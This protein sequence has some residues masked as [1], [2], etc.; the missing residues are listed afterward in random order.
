[1]L[2]LFEAISAPVS[3]FKYDPELISRKDEH[4]LLSRIITL[5]FGTVVFRGVE[6]RRRIVQFGWDYRFASRKATPAAPIPAFLLPLRE[7]AAA[8]ADV[9]PEQLEEVL[10]TEYPPGAG[11]GWHRDAPPFGIVVGV[12]LLSLCKFRLKPVGTSQ[13]KIVT[14]RLE[15]RSAYV[16]AGEARSS[17]LHSIPPAT[18][19]RYSITFRTIRTPADRAANAEE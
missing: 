7:R 15:P 11:I 10:V 17:W 19:L 5:P 9:R 13:G 12:S 8:L 6:A 16:L 3:G 18:R 14:V 4:E 2:S 1:M